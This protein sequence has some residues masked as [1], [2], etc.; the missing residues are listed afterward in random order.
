LNTNEMA[1]ILNISPDAVRKSKKRLSLKIAEN[2]EQS[3]DE[4][5]NSLL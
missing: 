1:M 3:F 4:F 5:T 2:L